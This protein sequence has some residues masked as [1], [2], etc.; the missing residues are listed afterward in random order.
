MPTL[1]HEIRFAL[2]NL[3]KSPGTT[4]LAIVV[5]ALGIG[6]NSAMFNITNA[7]LFKPYAFDEPERLMSVVSRDTESG[8]YR[9]VSFPNYA[10]LRESSTSFANLA[11]HNMA[12]AG[13]TEGEETRR[14]FVAMVSANYFET[15]GVQPVAGRFL[16][17]DEE[18]SGAR[19][20]VISHGFFERRDRSADV[21]GQA[22]TLNGLAYT[23]VGV[24][25]PRFGGT[26]ALFSPEL[27][28][29][30]DSAEA[31][32]NDFESD[33]GRAVLDRSNHTWILFG[34][35]RA[36]VDPSSADADM[37]R[38]GAGLAASFPE[39]NEDY[40]YAVHPMS[41]ISVSTAPQTDDEMGMLS[42]LLVSM[43]TVL[44]LVAGLNLA[45]LQ[46]ARG[47][48]RRREIA[49]RFALGSGRLSVIRQLMVESLLLALGAGVLGLAVGWAGP[50]ML[51]TSIERFAPFELML[52]ID[53]DWR[54]VAATVG[55]CVLAA[56]FVGLIPAWRASR[57]NLVADLA[58]K[59][60]GGGVKRGRW[61]ARSDVPVLFEIALS[62]V[63]LVAAGLFLKGAF[64]AANVDPGF[65]LDR[66]AIAEIDSQLVGY[67]DEQ[68]KDLLVRLEQRLAGIP[69]VRSVGSG[70]IVP[71]G[72]VSLGKAV[73]PSEAG[74]EPEGDQ[75]VGASF[76]VAGP[77][78]FE[79]MGIPLL[80]GRTFRPGEGTE[81]AVIDELLAQRLWPDEEALGRHLRVLG[82][83]T[84]ELAEVEVIGVV[85]S[86]RD[87][88]FDRTPGPHLW[89]SNERQFMSNAH[90]HL[91]FDTEPDAAMLGQ[92]RAAIRE[93]DG[94]LPVLAL[95]SMRD[96]L[97]SSVELWVLRTGGRLFTVFAAVALLLTL[98]G[99]Y[100]VRAYSVARRSREIGIR[101]ALGSSVADTLRMIL[102]E[103]FR[104]ALVGSVLGLIL[105][106][107]AAR[108]LAGFLF[109]V[110]ATDPLVF[111]VSFVLLFV[112]A[113]GACLPPARRA[114]RVDP[115]RALRTD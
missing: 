9:G 8:R 49:V 109:E 62:M 16:L 55:F 56:F 71:F 60:E 11:A 57:P 28:V 88:V 48:A 74:E 33:A 20:A 112:V 115:L 94:R 50:R 84:G 58:E 25:P 22:I 47:L 73:A 76:N 89:L 42:V 2:R 35:L 95:R 64:T 1:L 4:A 110:S 103:G 101:M 63:L 93:V 98:A 107:G 69:G 36:G 13:I 41:R 10:D 30:I 39:V 21:V 72:M 37:A 5:L 3:R 79:T 111:G 59:I 24:A 90:L 97:E 45:T 44:L 108:L 105:A 26:S 78:Y 18:T 19:V 52:R 38:V 99:V 27:W 53:L 100:G 81:V 43:A 61:I 15:F 83:D 31:L 77:G 70:G 104:L 86:I 68:G 87:S 80:R 46:G 32:Q 14:A 75:R 91:R 34:R 114:A 113:T 54:V 102:R 82:G 67:E 92:V 51:M 40:T 85:G 106:A 66:Q 29:P 96:H 23:I 17:P 65:V 12:M 7:L 6:G